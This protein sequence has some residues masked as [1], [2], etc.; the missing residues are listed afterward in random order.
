MFLEGGQQLNFAVPVRYALG[1]LQ[2]SPREKRLDSVFAGGPG[3]TPLTSAAAPA[4]ARAPR[5]S[6]VGT[7]YV[8]QSWMAKDATRPRAMGGL[9]ISADESTGL[10]AL[11]PDTASG[12]ALVYGVV[13]FRTNAV[14]QVVLEAGGISYDGYQSDDG[15]Y[16]TADYTDKKS[17]DT[18][19]IT[20]RG[21][22]YTNALSNSGGLYRAQVRTQ[23]M[24]TGGVASNSFT[25]WSGNAAVVVANDSVWIDLALSNASGGTVSLYGASALGTNNTFDIWS[26][27]ANRRLQG[28][29]SRGLLTAQWTDIRD[30]GRFVGTL[31]ATDRKSVV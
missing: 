25:D 26:S 13:T 14:G 10:L 12:R 22:P 18:Y 21:V 3:H 2:S 30:I 24:S 23:W 1:L 15:V 4:R 16:L 19:A 28:S 27:P 17:G 31:Q 5:G 11:V 20:F 9:L 8:I 29:V 7:Y 6:L